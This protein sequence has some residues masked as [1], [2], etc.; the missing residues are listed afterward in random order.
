MHARRRR[1]REER[2]ARLMPVLAVAE[3]LLPLS[4]VEVPPEGSIDWSKVPPALDP[5]SAGECLI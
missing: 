1:K 2:D 3:P 5:L 4:P